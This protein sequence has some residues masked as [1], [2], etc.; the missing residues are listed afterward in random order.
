MSE[1]K[2]IS[3]RV[4]LQGIRKLATFLIVL[5]VI[6][7]LPAGDIRWA[8]G[9]L[10]LGVFLALTVVATVYLWRANPDIFVARIRVTRAGSKRWDK[11]MV[12]L[13]MLSFM[14]LFPLAALDSARF[15]WS[16]VPAWLI[17]LGY[18]PL[19]VGFLISIWGEAV[20]KFAE[21]TVRIQTDRGH[22]VI[23]TGPYAIIRHP[24]YSGALLM[25][26]GIPLT[27][28]SYWSFLPAA[29]ATIVLV[30]RTILEDRTLQMELAGYKDYAARVPHRLIP[31]IW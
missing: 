22:K 4:F 26:A 19:C 2:Q 17:V 20:N 30:V 5:G 10:F 12:T 29:A 18:V 6:M 14:V 1:G 25:F 11:V 28:G 15:H 31:D 24:L 8:E 7:F 13:L 16:H 21:P 23:D 9:W 3:T 27:L